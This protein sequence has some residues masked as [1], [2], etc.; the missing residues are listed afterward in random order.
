MVTVM[1]FY[2]KW[3]I[4]H[5]LHSTRGLLNFWLSIDFIY[6]KSGYFFLL[7][8]DCFINYDYFY[9]LTAAFI[10]LTIYQ[11]HLDRLVDLNVVNHIF[12]YL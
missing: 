7:C 4:V 11:D 2:L 1:Q 9:I 10:G 8:C 12:F 5:I 3:C 6:C